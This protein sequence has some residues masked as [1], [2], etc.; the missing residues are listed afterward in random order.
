MKV[1]TVCLNFS[2]TLKFHTKFSVSS[3]NQLIYQ[4]SLCN[5][6]YESK[7]RKSISNSGGTRFVDYLQSKNFYTT[8]KF[9][10]PISIITSN[11]SKYTQLFFSNLVVHILPRKTIWK[12]LKYLKKF[13]SYCGSSNFKIVLEAYENTVDI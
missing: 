3:T 7:Y 4:T 13:P 9:I 12:R 8:I 1:C 6:E 2:D 5:F 10:S 11:R